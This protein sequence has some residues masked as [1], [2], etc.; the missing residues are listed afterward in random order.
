MPHIL[1]EGL[2]IHMSMNLVNSV[3]ALAIFSGK[4]QRALADPGCPVVL[5]RSVTLWGIGVSLVHGVVGEA[6][7]LK[8]LL[9][10]SLIVS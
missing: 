9:Y 5:M 7:S 8:S 1:E 3:F 2:R 4:R 10:G 6:T